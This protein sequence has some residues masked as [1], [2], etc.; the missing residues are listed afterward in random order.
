MDER[1]A[2]NKAWSAKPAHVTIPRDE[3]GVG[4]DG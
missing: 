2:V 4:H 1:T 3:E